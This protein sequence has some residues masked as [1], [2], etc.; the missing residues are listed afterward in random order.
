M[1][2]FS[3]LLKEKSTEIFEE[4]VDKYTVYPDAYDEE[5]EEYLKILSLYKEIIEMMSQAFELETLTKFFEEL[6][7]FKISISMPYIILVNEL[8]GLKNI[9]ISQIATHNRELNTHIADLLNIFTH[10]NDSIAK[11]YL[12]QYVETLTSANTLRINSL[13]DLIEKNLIVHYESHLE[14]LSEL[15]LHIKNSNA[16]TQVELNET[17]CEFGQWLSGDAKQI[18]KNNSKYKVI[19]TLHQNLHLFARKIY[20]KLSSS[21]YHIL[22]TYLEKC[23]LIS[24]S[25]GTELALIDNVL[26]NTK[27]TKDTLTGAL[28]REALKS[29]FENQYEL[30]LAT[31]RS[32]VLAICDLDFFKQVNDTFGHIA[33]DRVLKSFV[34]IVR[35]N[36]RNSDVIIRYGGEE[37]IIMLPAISKEKGKE[38]LDKIRIAFEQSSI[39]FEGQ[40]IQTTVSLGMMEIYPKEE[41]HKGFVEK[42]I[43][44]VDQKLYMAKKCGRNRVEVC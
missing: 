3:P 41:F 26:M 32:F 36:I 15:A 35:K 8:Y 28:N 44:I 37:F 1:Y 24:L 42:Y 43:S 2:D 29:V 13:K 11:I 33:G 30:S 40:S 6:A 22:I 17:K 14:W 5:N 9:F 25:I 21:E 34:D 10:I 12:L 23:E 27:V 16:Y 4:F 7:H 31:N 18:I 20:D 39:D 19:D 38:I